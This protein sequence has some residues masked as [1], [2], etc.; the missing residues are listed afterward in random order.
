MDELTEKD[1]KFNQ[2]EIN[3]LKKAILY[4]KFE[5]EETSSLIFSG[6]ELI[7]SAFDKL[8]INSDSYEREMKFY[9]RENPD[10]KDFIEKKIKRQEGFNERDSEENLI[11]NEYVRCCMHPFK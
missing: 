8:L 1:V 9:Y 11:D 7:N 2:G 3:A 6:S 5:C 4:L 10:S